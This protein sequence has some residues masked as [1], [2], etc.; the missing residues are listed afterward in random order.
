M[1]SKLP[2]YSTCPVLRCRDCRNPETTS[3]QGQRGPDYVAEQIARLK[4]TAEAIRAKQAQ[5][6]DE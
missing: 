6:D 4:A 3:P 5:K 1:T 2:C